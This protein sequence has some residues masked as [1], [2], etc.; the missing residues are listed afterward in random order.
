MMT[1]SLSI[2]IPTLNEHENLPPALASCHPPEDVE[3]I[4]VDG[5][6]TDGTCEL[7]RQSGVTL[8]ASEPGRGKQ[9]NVGARMAKGEILLFLHG[10]TVLPEGYQAQILK[11]LE[12]QGVVAGAFR[13]SIKGKPLSLR[14][15]ETVVNLRSRILQMPFGDQALFLRRGVFEQ[16][17]GFR[18][19]SI[20]EDFDLVRRLRKR[21]EIGIAER[22][23]VTSGRRWERLGPWRTTLMNQIAMLPTANNVKAEGSGTAPARIGAPGRVSYAHS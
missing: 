3:I 17:G 8:V 5:G 21:G 4:V 19:I 23:V 22:P 20:M 6:S 12:L 1:P 7:V 9:M 18:E 15:I 16:A 13:L 11:V 14:A 2:I 10:D